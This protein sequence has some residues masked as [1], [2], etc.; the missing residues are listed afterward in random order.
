MNTKNN[1]PCASTICCLDRFGP[2]AT[3]NARNQYQE[4]MFDFDPPQNDQT[5]S[6]LLS[7]LQVAHNI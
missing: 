6:C 1:S 4:E 5:Q 7:S 2:L 3:Q